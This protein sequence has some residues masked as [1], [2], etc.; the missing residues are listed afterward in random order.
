MFNLFKNEGKVKDP[1]CNMSVDKKKTAFSSV[2]KEKL[3]YF[4]SENCKIAFDINKEM[5][6]Q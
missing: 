6:A 2:Y 5:Y 1:V 3:Y 4:C